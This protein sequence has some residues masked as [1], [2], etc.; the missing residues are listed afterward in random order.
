MNTKYKYKHDS[1]PTPQLLCS[2][3][4]ITLYN[5]LRKLVR[6]TD[7]GP[8]LTR[9][10]LFRIIDTLMMVRFEYSV[11]NRKRR[12]NETFPH[13][14]QHQMKIIMNGH[15]ISFLYKLCLTSYGL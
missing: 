11:V 5:I 2:E 7:A 1:T 8:V 13:V 15:D 4:I 12:N 3:F 10:L 14:S 6:R 9:S